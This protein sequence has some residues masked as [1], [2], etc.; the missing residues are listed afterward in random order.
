MNAL[1]NALMKVVLPL[2]A[3]VLTQVVT[4]QQAIVLNSRDAS[5]SVIDLATDKVSTVS[6]VGK[7]PHHLYPS[8][9]G[10]QVWVANAQSDDLVKINPATGQTMQRVKGIAD[11]Y[12]LGFTTD[13]LWF[14][15]AC[16]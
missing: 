12:Q 1:M 10:K 3:M 13:G 11:P 14:Q 6:G 5:L 7:E 8:P 2:A 15:S 9:D 4:A 16:A